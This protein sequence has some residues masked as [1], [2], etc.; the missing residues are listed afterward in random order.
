MPSIRHPEDLVA[1]RLPVAST[2]K[3]REPGGRV[4]VIRFTT[5]ITNK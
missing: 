1:V 2:A 3:T 4:G 5:V